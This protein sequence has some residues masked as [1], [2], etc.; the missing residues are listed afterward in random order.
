MRGPGKALLPARHT[1]V[2]PTAGALCP[3]LPHITATLPCPLLQVARGERSGSH[4]SIPP[5]YG[6]GNLGEANVVLNLLL[7]YQQDVGSPNYPAWRAHMDSLM[8][9]IQH[10]NEARDHSDA[11]R[12]GPAAV[13]HG[14]ATGIPAYGATAA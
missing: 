4:Y 12:R 2:V 13:P 3:N 6:V 11:A 14:A 5:P 8:E 1:E 10:Q 7:D 9:C